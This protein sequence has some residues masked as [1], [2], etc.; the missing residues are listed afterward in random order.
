MLLEITKS[1]SKVEWG[2]VKKQKRQ[3]EPKIWEADISKSIRILKWKPKHNLKEGLQK[4][5]R[6]FKNNLDLYDK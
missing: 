1:K 5:F 4:T 3:I 6:W 2:K